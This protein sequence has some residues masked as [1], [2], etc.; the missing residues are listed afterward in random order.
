MVR[1]ESMNSDVSLIL[2]VDLFIR[3]TFETLKGNNNSACNPIQASRPHLWWVRSSD[4]K[5]SGTK[6]I[7]ADIKYIL[8]LVI[9]GQTSNVGFLSKSG[10]TC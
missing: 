6:D 9:W 4:C 3:A 10:K 7:E 8:I 5:Y 2:K 1:L